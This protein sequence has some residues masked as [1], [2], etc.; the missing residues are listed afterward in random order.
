MRLKKELIIEDAR[1]SPSQVW[2]ARH[3]V[4]AVQMNQLQLTYLLI[5]AQMEHIIIA[6]IQ[7]K[8]MESGVTLTQQNI[9][10]SIAIPWPSKLFQQ[11]STI[12]HRLKKLWKFIITLT[13][14]M[15]WDAQFQLA[16]SEK[17][18]VCRQNQTVDLALTQPQKRM[19]FLSQIGL[20]LGM[21]WL[22]RR[23]K[24]LLKPIWMENFL[25]S[26]CWKR[27]CL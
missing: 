26:I 10:G 1:R 17:L 7:V 14:P 8:M 22:I 11:S 21:Q 4:Q 27:N 2:H 5:M 20:I 19:M 9:D 25:P 24:S 3:G 15:K 18:G 16:K 12:N 6:E 23:T 13:T